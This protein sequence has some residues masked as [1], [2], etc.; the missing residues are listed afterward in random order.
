M[1]TTTEHT[2]VLGI[3]R[4]HVAGTSEG[5][6]GSRWIS[7]GLDGLCT[8]VG[9]DT[10]SAAFELVDGYREWG[11]ENGGVVLHL[12]GQ[13]ELLTAFDGDGSTEYATGILQHEVHFLGSDFLGG[14][15]QVALVF[16]VFVIHN[17][18]KLTVFE[19]L[20]GFLYGVE[21][22]FFHLLY[23]KYVLPYIML[24]FCFLSYHLGNAVDNKSVGLR[25]FVQVF[26]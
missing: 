17:D 22:C 15:N 16:T 25:D 14:D 23:I 7:Q 9:T 19:V 21:S 2:V 10:G 8:V 5:L 1:S 4:V 11:A 18:D 12:M 24:C 20:Y 26:P 13:V 6:R 3:E